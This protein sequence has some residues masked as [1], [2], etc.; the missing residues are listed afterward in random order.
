[1]SFNQS[2]GDYYVAIKHRN[3]KGIITVNLIILSTTTTVVGLSSDPTEVLG[4]A[5]SLVDMN[6]IYAMYGGDF[7]GD[8]QIQN[9]DLLNIYSVIGVSGYSDADLDM[10]NQI[11]NSDVFILLPNIGKGIQF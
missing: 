2:S 8:G 6:G 5:T 11:Q 1:L 7:S 10:N 3:Y 4:D 9:A